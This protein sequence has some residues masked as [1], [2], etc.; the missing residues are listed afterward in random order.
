[1]FKAANNAMNP[2]AIAAGNLFTSG[3]PFH[4]K[5]KVTNA[6][7]IRESFSR[8]SDRLKNGF[9]GILI[10]EVREEVKQTNR[11]P[12]FIDNIF[13]DLPKGECLT[14]TEEIQSVVIA[15]H[16]TLSNR[17]ANINN[18]S[19]RKAM[20]DDIY[21]ELKRGYENPSRL[22]Y[23]TTESICDGLK[24]KLI[25][26]L[27]SYYNRK[28]KETKVERE[29]SIA[30]KKFEQSSSD[31]F[32]RTRRVKGGETSEESSSAFVQSDQSYLNGVMNDEGHDTEEQEASDLYSSKQEYVALVTEVTKQITAQYIKSVVASGDLSEEEAQH[33]TE[34]VY[35]FAAIV[36]D[37]FTKNKRYMKLR[38]LPEEKLF[39][40]IEAWFTAHVDEY[41]MERK[42]F[43]QTTPS[44]EPT[45]RGL[46]TMTM[47]EGE[48][49][50]F[51]EGPVPTDLPKE[52]NKG[53]V[54]TVSSNKVNPKETLNY[55]L[56]QGLQ[57][58][59][60]GWNGLSDEYYRERL[61]KF[62]ELTL[63]E[64]GERIVADEPDSENLNRIAEHLFTNINNVIAASNKFKDVI[65]N[66]MTIIED[67]L[68]EASNGNTISVKV[69]NSIQ[70]IH[71]GKLSAYYGIVNNDDFGRLICYEA[72]M[73]TVDVLKKLNYDN[74][75]EPLV[76]K[77]NSLYDSETISIAKEIYPEATTVEIMKQLDIQ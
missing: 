50:S 35:P 26:R 14:T 22:I 34:S 60:S 17:I 39:K 4:Y 49:V 8:I 69:L 40:E 62:A 47:G 37:R 16:R 54:E 44:T 12:D 28:K 31:F 2:I 25:K 15:L 41:R 76:K 73:E 52:L 72:A 51:G 53:E 57:H 66:Q 24:V 11:Y 59:P 3:N 75:V 18:V 48:L 13:S 58:V 21:Y 10:E 43:S 6:V 67:T 61:R 71:L 5:A 29:L 65:F 74:L 33:R 27:D 68:K 46:V 32:A 63:F 7:K 45:K 9:K 64:E 20:D 70:T 23:S 55:V 77:I 42:Q 36:I 30:K 1:M 19:L 56:D 38:H